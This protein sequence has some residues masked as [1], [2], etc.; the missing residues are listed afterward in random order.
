M[1]QE[2]NL[3]SCGEAP[4]SKNCCKLR[5]KSLGF[6]VSDNGNPGRF[7]MSREL[8][9][10]M[11]A[12][13]WSSARIGRAFGVTQSAAWRFVAR[14]RARQVERRRPSWVSGSCSTCRRWGWFAQTSY[15]KRGARAFCSFECYRRRGSGSCIA[16]QAARSAALKRDRFTRG[17]RRGEFRSGL[18]Y[19]ESIARRQTAQDDPG[20]TIAPQGG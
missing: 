8:A 20:A 7:K 3:C 11:A 13:G 16:S 2:V 15:R 6:L 19:A 18:S 4:G 17:P 10:H 12:C 5:R 9:L 1:A 14:H